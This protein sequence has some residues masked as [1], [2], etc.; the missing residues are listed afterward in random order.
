M[1]LQ[2]DWTVQIMN[3]INH[4]L[5]EKMKIKI[6]L[7]NDELG[8]KIKTKFVGLRAKSYSYLMNDGSE[9]TKAKGIKKC[10]IKRK[11]KFE[12]DKICL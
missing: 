1:M 6:G 12:N 8:E 4:C 7:I 3:Q 2:L 9:D 5:N 10:V 11:L